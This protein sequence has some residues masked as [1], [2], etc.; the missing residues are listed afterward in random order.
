MCLDKKTANQIIIASNGRS[1]GEMYK[2]L[3]RMRHQLCSADPAE[4]TYSSEEI[5]CCCCLGLCVGTVLRRAR[6][7][8][9]SCV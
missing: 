6:E 9:K 2:S 5:R 3:R 7:E 1:N 4:E 8:G